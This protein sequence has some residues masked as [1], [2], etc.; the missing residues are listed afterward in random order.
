MIGGA[1]GALLRY[2]VSR[3]C[4]GVAVL[5][6]PVGTF[7]VNIAGCFVLGALNSFASHHTTLPQGL[8]LMLTVGMCGAFT[9]FSTFSGESIRLLNE[10]HILHALL[11]VTTSVV[12]GLLFFWIGSKI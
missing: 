3:A 12:A 4:A 10:G 6:I 5:S 7:I 9:T 1:I 11:Y 8:V 2:I